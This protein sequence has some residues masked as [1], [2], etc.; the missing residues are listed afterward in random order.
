MIHSCHPRLTNPGLVNWVVVTIWIA[1]YTMGVTPHNLLEKDYSL[2]G[3]II[4]L[5]HITPHSVSHS[6]LGLPHWCPPH[7]HKPALCLD[8]G[9]Y[10]H[11]ML[12][13]QCHE[14]FEDGSNSTHFW[15]LGDGLLLGLPHCRRWWA[16]GRSCFQFSS[17]K[18][19]MT[20]SNEKMACWTLKATDSW[21]WNP[22]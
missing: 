22:C 21:R 20:W 8:R 14:P 6:L 16:S 9:Y 13:T 11:R 17:G 7:T 10:L 2:I 3:L 12:E 1:D 4:V 18:V 15:W 19:L 5:P